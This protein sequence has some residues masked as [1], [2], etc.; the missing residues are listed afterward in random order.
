M[1]PDERRE[2]VMIDVAI[3]KEQPPRLSR[4]CSSVVTTGKL[5]HP[6]PDTTIES[7]TTVLLTSS[8]SN[9][10]RSYPLSSLLPSG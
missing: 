8:R 7:F 3:D 4:S 1:L 6:R 5:C 2:H 10:R 9:P